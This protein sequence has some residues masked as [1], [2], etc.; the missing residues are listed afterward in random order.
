MGRT[1]KG[2][3]VA[4]LFL[5]IGG[6]TA[7]AS[8]EGTSNGNTTD[9]VNLEPKQT[10]TY[11][12]LAGFLADMPISMEL[13]EET[14]YHN[15]YGHFF[16]GFYRYDA[17]GGP[18]AVYGNLEDGNRLVLTEQGGWDNE[19]HT[20]QGRWNKNGQFEG[21]WINGNGVDKHTFELRPDREAVPLQGWGAEDSL[22]AFPH[23][24]YSPK[25]YYGAEWLE[26]EKG[27]RPDLRPFINDKIA[28]GLLAQNYVQ[29]ASWS[30]I[31]KQQ[32]QDYYEEYC[33][34]MAALRNVGML[35]SLADPEAFLSANYNYNSSVQV[36]FNSPTLLTLGY[37]DYVYTGGAHG[38]FGTRVE[39]YDL[40]NRRTLKL[41][42]ILLPG[43]ETQI[44]KALERAVRLKYNLK[45]KQSLD[46]IL[47]EKEIQPNEN[48]GVTDK[49]IFFVYSPY[50]IAPYA[51]G[52]IELYVS[53]EQITD[54]VQAAW[55]PEVLGKELDDGL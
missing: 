15:D 21:F 31:L 17:Y 38:M 19:A 34:E 30:E 44:A 46:A 12:H 37:T 18:I 47:F 22:A 48:F 26:V 4:I 49:G 50:D 43:Y 11:Y 28:A 52:E 33:E 27:E 53:F 40:E 54:F 55:L 6:L 8:D 32:C 10:N 41:E 24:Q 42:D 16:R 9:K 36:Y 1:Q 51:A 20:F 23:W 39:S 13:I 2:I 25:M 5:I 3:R 14:N 35:D 45:P 7:C 29:G